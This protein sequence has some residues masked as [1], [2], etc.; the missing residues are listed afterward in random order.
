M[1]GLVTDFRLFDTGEGAI[2][3]DTGAAE[4]SGVGLP[5]LYVCVAVVVRVVAL[6]V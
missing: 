6:D 1:G 4:G 3:M 5:N 2:E